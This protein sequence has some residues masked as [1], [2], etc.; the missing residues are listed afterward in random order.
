[1]SA[2]K[3]GGVF[4]RLPELKFLL[5]TVLSLR[6]I[7]SRRTW[8][9]RIKRM[10]ERSCLRTTSNMRMTTMKVKISSK[11]RGRVGQRIKF[12]S[13]KA[14]NAARGEASML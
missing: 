5:N 2:T 14:W 11:C 7:V 10:K 8:V 6:R 4:Y 1:M 3:L 9:N 12:D 13:L